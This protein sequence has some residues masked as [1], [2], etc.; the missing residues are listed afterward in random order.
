[1][2]PPVRVAAYDT[3]SIFRLIFAPGRPPRPAHPVRGDSRPSSRRQ[4][5]RP[6]FQPRSVLRAGRRVRSRSSAIPSPYSSAVPPR[7]A[8]LPWRPRASRSHR[9]LRALDQLQAR[10]SYQPSTERRIHRR[11]STTA[12]GQFGTPLTLSSPAATFS[13]PPLMLAYCSRSR[14]LRCSPS[15]PKCSCRFLQPRCG[16][17]ADRRKGAARHVWDPPLTLAL[18]LLASLLLPALT[19]EYRLRPRYSVRH[20]GR[21]TTARRVAEPAG[22]TRLGWSPRCG[23]RRSPP[24]THRWP[25]CPVRR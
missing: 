2:R 7:L 18:V 1:M 10:Q 21:P 24:R 4:S 23:D 3:L 12:R 11:R 25:R 15:R 14:C 17:P 22:H 5:P 13:L 6:H 8:S 9:P 20:D 19:D 16:R